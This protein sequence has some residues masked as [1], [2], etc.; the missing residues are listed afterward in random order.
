MT[1]RGEIRIRLECDSEGTDSYPDYGHTAITIVVSGVLRR[2][3]IDWR[4]DVTADLEFFELGEVA[5]D[6]ALVL[7]DMTAYGPEVG[8]VTIAEVEGASEKFYLKDRA[9]IDEDDYSGCSVGFPAFHG[10]TAHAYH[11]LG[12]V[13]ILS[14]PFVSKAMRLHLEGGPWQCYLLEFEPGTV[15]VDVIPD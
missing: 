7:W 1:E 13:H 6:V 15:K 10:V 4:K 5:G 12:T 3:V 2:R 11:R 8:A 14:G 9:V